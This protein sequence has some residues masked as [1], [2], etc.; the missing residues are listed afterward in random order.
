MLRHVTL[1]YVGFECVRL[2]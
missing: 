1:H 2:G